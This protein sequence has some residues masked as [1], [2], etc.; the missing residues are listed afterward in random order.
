M[1]ILLM[2]KLNTGAAGGASM[3]SIIVAG[4]SCP[5]CFPAFAGL[6]SVFGISSGWLPGSSIALI[7]P[8]LV[9][10]NIA[11]STWEVSRHKS[12]S[13][14]ALMLVG[15]V[16]FFLAEPVFQSITAY[17]VGLGVMLAMAIFNIVR[18][19]HKVCGTD[20]CSI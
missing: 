13:R 3:M 4:L 8:Y 6:A 9:A 5:A 2:K 1:E 11:I 16:I 17:N 14:F 18:P 7:I 19:K 12:Y 20:G 15:P 10:L